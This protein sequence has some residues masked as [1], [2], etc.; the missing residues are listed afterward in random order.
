[1]KSKSCSVL[2]SA[3]C[4]TLAGIAIESAPAKAVSI[5]NNTNATALVNALLGSNSGITIVGTPTLTGATGSAGTFNGGNTGSQLGITDGIVLSTG[6]VTNGTA[7]GGLVDNNNPTYTQFLTTGDSDLSAIAGTT[8]TDAA[9][10]EFDFTSSTGNLFL[11]DYVFA[12]QEY[13]DFVG[14]QFN[15]AFAFF[16]DGVNIANIPN[17]S[18]PVAINNVNSTANSGYFRDNSTDAIGL[19]YGGF[20]TVLQAKALNIGLGNHTFKIAIADAGVDGIGTPDY[21]LDSA[22][23]LKNGSFR[24]SAPSVPEP[25]TVIGTLIGGTAAFRMRKK[26]KSNTKV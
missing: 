1:M 15:D 21:G 11:L 2:F 25:F 13:P 9:I 7:N 4:L 24:A 20:T 17:T 3:T 16:V 6:A 19:H 18:T 5:T 12:S 23:F 10:L 26:L 8:T 14:S 22:V